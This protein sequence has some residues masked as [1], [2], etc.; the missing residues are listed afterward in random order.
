MATDQKKK[1][2]AILLATLD[3]FNKLRMP[4]AKIFLE[5]VNKGEVLGEYENTTIREVMD[6]RRLFYTLLERNPE[7]KELAGNAVDM[8][9]EIIEKNEENKKK[10][11][12]FTE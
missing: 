12:K 2:K 6:D 8:W 4:Q 1:D 9:E 11:K 3:R 7:Y 5:K 10:Q